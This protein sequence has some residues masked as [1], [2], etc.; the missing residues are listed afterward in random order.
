MDPEPLT[1]P[2]AAPLAET[3]PGDL[4]GAAEPIPGEAAALAPA[5]A[6]ALLPRLRRFAR[7]LS[8][9]F[10]A[11]VLTQV[12]S[13]SAGLVLVRTLPVRE[14]ALYTLALSVVTFF[15][16]V[17]DLGSTTSLLYFFNRTLRDG[18][19]FSLYLAAVRSLRRWA[20]LAGAAAVGVALPR[21]ASAKGFGVAETALATAGVLLCVWFQI[22]ASLSVLA[23]RLGD[24]YNRSYGAEIA[25]GGLRLAV[26]A[27][28]ALASRLYGWLAV[29]GN[30]A[31]IAVTAFVARA[32]PAL[33]APAAPAP[34]PAGEAGEAGE[35]A[36]D[37]L[38][39][40][41]RRVL[42]Y[43][44]PTLPS[45]LY[46]SIQGPLVVWLSATFGATR[47]IAEVGALARLGMLLGLFSNL[48][49]IVLLPHLARISDDR[50][51][52]ARFLQFGT[53]LAAVAAA[54]LAVTSAFPRGFLA[55]LGQHYS[56]LDG[57]LVLVAWGAGLTLVGGYLVSVNLAR[58]WT[59]WQAPAM[60]LLAIT[61]ALMV[62]LLP[63]G[64]TR[65]VLT[66][67]VLTGATG[68]LLQAV[69]AGV[70]FARPALVHWE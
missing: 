49:A 31:A 29:L 20:F 11:Q 64:T 52:R 67:N 4:A 24:R 27:V 66:F 39:P 68:L 56:G 62:K 26:V 30:A 35:S 10:T 17:S 50:L 21:A 60:L 25:G 61:Q 8:A 33:P 45:A 44:L 51:Y 69:T 5:D 23:L 16:F 7:A 34:T 63:L 14:F 37:D 55:I 40:Y 48:S 12:L 42:R 36:R 65:G 41:R 53:L 1:E 28:M 46:F 2:A 9:Y 57:E 47:N 13:L 6:A 70:G 59:R 3:I 38:A 19:E 15:T 32:R 58:S 22:G 18:S 43:L 54:L